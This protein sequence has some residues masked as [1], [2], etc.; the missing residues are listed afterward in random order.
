[1]GRSGDGLLAIARRLRT[2]P[3]ESPEM[4]RHPK[5]VYELYLSESSW[6]EDREVEG[7]CDRMGSYPN[8]AAVASKDP[9]APSSTAAA[10]E[11]RPS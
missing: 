3:L 6:L 7:E 9:T 8:Y 11:K 5:E 10:E 1:V 2:K 4:A